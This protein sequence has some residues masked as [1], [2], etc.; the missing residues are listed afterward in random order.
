MHF[1]TESLNEPTAKECCLQLRAF[2][3]L[4]WKSRKLDI[5]VIGRSGHRLE[6]HANVNVLQTQLNS[7]V[8]GRKI[9]T[10]SAAALSTSTAAALLS[11]F[12]CVWVCMLRGCDFSHVR[13]GCGSHPTCFCIFP[14]FT[15]QRQEQQQQEQ[16]QQQ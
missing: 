9:F 1:F 6:P 7:K 3:Q 13:V 12:V 2:R 4:Q 8:A 15:Q 11:L 5:R 10:I 14:G 16:Q